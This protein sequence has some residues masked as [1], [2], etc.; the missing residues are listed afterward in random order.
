MSIYV[1]TQNGF[2][3][4]GP[5]QWNY[6]SFKNTLTDELG[7]DFDLP[8]TKEDDQMIDINETTKIYAA[9]LT[10]SVFDPRTHFQ[11]GPFWEFTHKAYGTY[12]VLEQPVEAV[13]NVL[14][15][16]V[17][18]NRWRK[19][20]AGVKTTVQGLEVTVDTNR[21]DRD[22]FVQQ[23]LLMGDTDT[24]KWKFPEGWLIL[25]KSDL[26]QIVFAGVTHVQNQFVWEAAKLAELDACVT[27]S[28]LLEVDVWN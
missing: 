11:H 23:F 27:N 2:V 21:G 25:S 17:T 5:R 20:V 10:D 22:V 9:E 12:Q 26:G 18:N 4:N 8:R 6:N 16:N 28:E 15:S 24:V 1:L 14:K 3:V 19:E 7:I 13:R